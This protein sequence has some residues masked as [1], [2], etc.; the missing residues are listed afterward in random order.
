M[1]GLTVFAA[2]GHAGVHAVDKPVAVGT[3]SNFRRVSVLAIFTILTVFSGSW[4]ACIFAVY[5][6]VAVIANVGRHTVFAISPSQI[7]PKVVQ[8]S[9]I[10]RPVVSGIM[11]ILQSLAYFF[12]P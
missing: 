6:P 4:N 12:Y 5:P 8:L 3:D 9:L 10:F 7:V 11:G 2:R 1:A